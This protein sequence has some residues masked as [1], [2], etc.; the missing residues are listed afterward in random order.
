MPEVGAIEGYIL[1]AHTEFGVNRLN[2]SLDFMSTGL[3]KLVSRKMRLKFLFLFFLNKFF[4]SSLRKLC[5]REKNI[6]RDIIV[7]VL[8]IV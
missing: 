1:K 7:R 6:F 2:T 8:R 4:A 5:F 3:K